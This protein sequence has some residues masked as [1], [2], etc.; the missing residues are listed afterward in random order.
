[1]TARPSVLVID[2]DP[3]LIRKRAAAL[4]KLKSQ[5]LGP[6]RAGQGIA[7]KRPQ[8]G[9]QLGRPQHHQ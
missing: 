1:M 5:L 3:A 7:V 2:D 6:Q 8:Q 9:Q 4:D